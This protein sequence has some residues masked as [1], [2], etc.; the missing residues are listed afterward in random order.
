MA[1]EKGE[2]VAV[3]REWTPQHETSL[4]SIHAQIDSWGRRAGEAPVRD[5]AEVEAA[6]DRLTKRVKSRKVT[7]H[8]TVTEYVDV[9]EDAE[10]SAPATQPDAEAPKKKGFSWF[11][12]KRKEEPAATAA[13]APEPV[14]LPPPAP[15]AQADQDAWDPGDSRPGRA[16]DPV[17]PL[18]SK[19]A[20]RTARR[21]AKKGSRKKR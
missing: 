9:Q 11:S 21:S 5:Y 16:V 4:T 19:A 1:K 13:P 10:A 12:R 2:V 7:V 3:V 20:K 15:A 18:Q 17:K 6:V 14:A 8:E